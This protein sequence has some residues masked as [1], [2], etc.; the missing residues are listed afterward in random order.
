MVDQGLLAGRSVGH[1]DTMIA[2]P[3][4]QGGLESDTQICLDKLVMHEYRRG[5][6]VVIKKPIGS[7]IPKNRENAARE[8]VK[9][10]VGQLLFIDT[11]MVFPENIIE[12]L[13]KHKKQIVSGLYH[14]KA[15]P[16][17]PIMARRD[18]SGGWRTV[19]K[20]EDNALIEVDAVGGGIVLIQTSVFDKVEQP[21]FGMVP[22]KD[23]LLLDEVERLFA[24]GCDIDYAVKK[25][26]KVRA[27]Q[28]A[29]AEIV[30]EDYYFC[31]KCR[32]VGIPVYVDT[33][34][35]MG[36]IGKYIYTYSDYEDQLNRGTFDDKGD[37]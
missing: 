20:W 37:K 17:V 12:E 2:I 11:D 24:P 21:W 18:K 1:I 3:S 16:Y 28:R 31:M 35:K 7:L 5:K 22:V 4:W 8:A 10:K 29:N 36:H 13:E 27:E 9:L 26:R 14:G 25:I 6:V 15:Y 19:V 32:K 30:G 34:L 33:S 23:V